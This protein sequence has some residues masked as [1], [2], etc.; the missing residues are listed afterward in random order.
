VREVVPTCGRLQDRAAA[1]KRRQQLGKSSFVVRQLSYDL[2]FTAEPHSMQL[3]YIDRSSVGGMVTVKLDY[4]P[5][6]AVSITAF[7]ACAGGGYAADR[8]VR[9]GGELLGLGAGASGRRLAALPRTGSERSRL[10]CR[11]VVHSARGIDKL[12]QVRSLL[13]S[14]YEENDNAATMSISHGS[15]DLMVLFR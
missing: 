7:D 3:R 11:G 10:L 6:D 12:H 5:A 13:R 2:L 1:A 15:F 4:S 8:S 9:L 14:D